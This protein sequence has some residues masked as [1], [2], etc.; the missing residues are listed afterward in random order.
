VA[1]TEYVTAISW[2]PTRVACVDACH[3]R[4]IDG[5]LSDVSPTG[6]RLLYVF[7]FFIF[8]FSSRNVLLLLLYTRQPRVVELPRRLVFFFLHR[9]ISCTSFSGNAQI[10]PEDRL[11]NYVNNGCDSRPSGTESVPLHTFPPFCVEFNYFPRP[12]HTA[13]TC[14]PTLFAATAATA[15][16]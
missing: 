7:F 3:K 15:H 16:L 4:M 14:R 13:C 1:V 8:R 11:I 2:N 12:S 9:F 6:R 10:R 5:E